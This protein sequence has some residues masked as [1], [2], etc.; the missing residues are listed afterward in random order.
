MRIAKV[1]RGPAAATVAVMATQVAAATSV[2][3]YASLSEPLIAFIVYSASYAFS[4]IALAV[5][6]MKRLPPTTTAYATSTAIGASAILVHAPTEPGISVAVSGAALAISVSA[7]SS[8]LVTYAG[9]STGPALSSLAFSVGS[10]SG[11]GASALLIAAGAQDITPLLSAG[12]AS[13]SLVMTAAM[14]RRFRRRL[15]FRPGGKPSGGIG[16]AIAVASAGGAM[17]S[18]ALTAKLSTLGSEAVMAVWFVMAAAPIGFYGRAA[19]ASALYKRV[20]PAATA[21]RGFAVIPAMTDPRGLAGLVL[22]LSSALV[23]SIAWAYLITSAVRAVMDKVKEPAKVAGIYAAS[24]SGSLGGSLTAYLLTSSAG[25]EATLA[26][27]GVLSLTALLLIRKN[28]L[29]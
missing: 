9:E 13:T 6:V 19:R 22:A 21:G 4:A 16:T 14:P 28:K 2:M 27:S 12:L 15:V 26:A 23:V 1:K 29:G 18:T 3:G 24:S 17:F 20:L 7:T 8:T 11:Y 5:P 10:L 25:A